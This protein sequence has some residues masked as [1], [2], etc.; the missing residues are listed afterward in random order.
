ML[1]EARKPDPITATRHSRWRRGIWA[2]CL[3]A[4]AALLTGCGVRYDPGPRYTVESFLL[5]IHLGS[6]ESAWQDL[7]ANLQQPGHDVAI[8]EPDGTA[9]TALGF[10]S[11]RV[12]P[13][14]ARALRSRLVPILRMRLRRTVATAHVV[15]DGKSGWVGRFSMARVDNEWIMTSIVLQPPTKPSP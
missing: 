3:V 4:S 9:A 13:A 5:Y 6:Y 2:F 1:P 10:P 14:Q 7:A 11:F 12:F 15:V 8:T